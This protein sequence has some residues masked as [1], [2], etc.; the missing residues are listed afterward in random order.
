MVANTYLADVIVIDI[1][2]HYGCSFLGS[3]RSELTLFCLFII[4]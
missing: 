3:E 1:R 4:F 2:L